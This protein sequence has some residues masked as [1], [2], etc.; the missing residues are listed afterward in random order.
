MTALPGLSARL[1]RFVAGASPQ[2]APDPQRILLIGI[3]P[4]AIPASTSKFFDTFDANDFQLVAWNAESFV[5]ELEERTGQPFAS[6]YHPFIYQRLKQLYDGKIAH[7]LSWIR[8]GH[9]LVIFPFPFGSGPHT[10]GPNG[11]VMPIEVNQFVPFN[12]VNL[13]RAGGHSLKAVE[14]FHTQFSEF[15]EVL[16]CEVLLSGEAILPLFRTDCGRAHRAEIAGAAFR[17][18][19]GAIVFSPPPKD[20]TNPKLEDYFGALAKLP[21]LLSSPL[22][23]LPER[24]GAPRRMALPL[25]ALAALLIGAV[26]LSPFWAPP[27]ARLLPW[28]EEKSQLARQDYAALAARLAE[29]E[30][31]PASP[32]FDVEAIKSVESALA[33]R[34]DQLDAALW[35]LQELPAAAPSNTP[36]VLTAPAT[37]AS[38]ST[39]QTAALVPPAASPHLSTEEIAELLARGDRLLRSG[40]VASARLFYERAANAGDGRAALRVGATFD[41]SFLDRDVLRGV[42]GEPAEARLWYQR[43][44][45]LGEPEAESRLRNLETKS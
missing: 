33:R 27:V 30:K 10:H 21:D 5:A 18:G 38:H 15:V 40:D 9:L 20:W 36:A 8:D 13:A 6:Y 23:P 4:A 17:I 19:R 24:K 14:E 25:A 16:K 1:S 37:T 29:I 32:S 39:E 26:V 7:L 31:R 2:M 11:L 41:P 35:R 44:R 43:A 34:V 45:D 22:D 42:R 12:L 3:S 28:G